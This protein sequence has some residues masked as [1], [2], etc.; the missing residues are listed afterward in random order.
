MKCS[1]RNEWWRADT[2]THCDHNVNWP[3]L[4][5]V[6]L[7]FLLQGLKY[8]VPCGMPYVYAGSRRRSLAGGALGR[9]R[10]TRRNPVRAKCCTRKSVRF[11]CYKA[12]MKCGQR[13]SSIYWYVRRGIW[14]GS[15]R[16]ADASERTP[17]TR[18]PRNSVRGPLPCVNVNVCQFFKKCCRFLQDAFG[19]S[20]LRL[21]QHF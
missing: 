3:P 16:T 21:R 13:G 14:E 19:N 2:V 10:G 4:A 18:V 9:R 17:G 8:V 5:I 20:S 7:P 15:W 1:T 11:T 6:M 12:V